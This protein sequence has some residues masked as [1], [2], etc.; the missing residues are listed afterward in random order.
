MEDVF[1][2]EPNE[3]T[4]DQAR[5]MEKVKDVAEI[6]YNEFCLVTDP[7]NGRELALAKTKLEEA[8][9]WAIKGITK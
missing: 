6:L 1:R 2:K 5:S 9:M 7:S 8:V 3:L 4:K